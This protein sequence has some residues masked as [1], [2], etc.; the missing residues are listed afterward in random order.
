MIEVVF[1]ETTSGRSPISDFVD[2]QSIETQAAL[3]AALEEVE[4]NA[5]KA[6]GVQFRQIQGKLWEI[7]IKTRS[8]EFRFLYCRVKEKLLILHTFQKKTAKTPKKDK[9]IALK[10]MKE[11]L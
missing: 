11:Y 8:G 5:F 2:E 6:K 1:Y 10:R 7:K 4:K 9:Q 3:I